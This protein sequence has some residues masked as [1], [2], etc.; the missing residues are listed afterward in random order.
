MDLVKGHFSAVIGGIGAPAHC[1]TDSGLLL[2]E[3]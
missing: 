3:N 1:V 2:M